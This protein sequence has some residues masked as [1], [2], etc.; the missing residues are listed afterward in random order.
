MILLSLFAI[1]AL[2][3]LFPFCQL[4]S[5]S[6]LLA[7]LYHRF[8]LDR[9]LLL[10]A[11][12]GLYMDLITPDLRLGIQGLGY[13]LTTLLLFPHKR[14]FFADKPLSICLFTAL[15][16]LVST[17]ILWILLPLSGHPFT[18]SKMLLVTDLIC[19]PCIDMVYAFL[20][21]CC[22]L[23]L[24]SSIKKR[25]WPHVYRTLLIY[26]RLKKPL[27]DESS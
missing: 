21:F 6:P 9:C 23:I 19:L 20:C 5:F 1:A 12:C 27:E 3:A 2:F 11:L 10:G 25:G 26:L 24:Y 7:L 15:I 17:L 22:P 16:S 18:L 4:L 13:V 14:H 8:P